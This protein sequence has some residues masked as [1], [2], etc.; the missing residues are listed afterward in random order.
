MATL[1][2]TR[3]LELP[4]ARIVGSQGWVVTP[5]HQVAVPLSW[6]ESF[7]RPSLVHIRWESE[8]HLSGTVLNLGTMNGAIN[9]GHFLLDGIG[10]L[11][12]CGLA[13]ISLA[14]VD[15]VVVPQFPSAGARAVLDDVGIPADKIVGLDRGESVTG[16]V[17]LAP[18]MPG[19]TRIY[20]PSLVDFL[21]RTRPPGSGEAR[22]RVMISRRGGRRPL[23]NAAAVEDLAVRHGFE[24]VTPESVD[25]PS[26]LA[27]A[28]VVV[29]SHG[30]ALADLTFCRPGT[31]VVELMPSDHMFPYWFTLAR[32]GGLAYSVVVGESRTV[33]DPTEWG[34]SPAAFEVPIDFLAEALTSVT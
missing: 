3:V 2:A 34:S 20:R 28:A 23:S 25:L 19:T 7:G 15:H 9:Y 27:E 18:S 21:R 31:R 12:V 1:P 24:V 32:A 33:R 29:G 16:D 17:V 14:E 6:Y 13:G 11:S 26:V 22:R 30:A 5:D 10:R 8:R 4:G